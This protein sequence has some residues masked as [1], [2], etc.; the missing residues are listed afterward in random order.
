MGAII[1]RTKRRVNFMVDIQLIGWV[2]LIN[3]YLREVIGKDAGCRRVAN[4]LCIKQ[5]GM[6][7]SMKMKSFNSVDTVAMI[8]AVIVAFTSLSNVASAAPASPG[9]G[10]KNAGSNNV[11][12][13]RWRGWR[14]GWGWGGV[15]AGYFPPYYHRPYYQPYYYQPYYYY[16]ARTY[17]YPRA[18][19]P[20]YAGP[21]VGNAVT[22]CLQRFQSYDPRS[23]TYL[24]YDGYRHPCP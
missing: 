24:G 4:L 12:A 22:Y 5:H 7:K 9:L 6:E 18:Y 11:A 19:Y 23:G 17:Y 8:A 15:G 3:G 14:L 1:M 16:S 20:V 21:V 13:V 2:I 10:I